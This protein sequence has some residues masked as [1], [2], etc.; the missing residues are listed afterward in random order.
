MAW[1]KGERDGILYGVIDIGSNT[2]R[3]MIYQVEQGVI[4]PV[5]NQKYAAGLAG[6]INDKGEM[7]PAGI[8]KAVE[9]LSELSRTASQVKLEELFAFATA[10]LRNSSNA[11]AVLRA[12]REA[13]GLE[14]RV[15]T[16]TEEA[17]F[18]YYGAIQS[19]PMDSG[20]LVDVGGGSTELVYYR[21]K[22]VFFSTSLPMGSLN[23]FARFVKEI[24]PT[25]KEMEQIQKEVCRQLETVNPPAVPLC[26]GTICGVGGTAR[27]VQRIHN[28]MKKTKGSNTYNTEFLGEFLGKMEAN[29]G[30]LIPRILKVAPERVHTLLPGMMIFRT[31][32]QTFGSEQVVTSPYG[33][34]EGYLYYILE[35]R[36]EL[37]E[38]AAP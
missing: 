7:T 17:V 38:T 16:G 30:K 9:V 25:R 31:I 20:L 4:T 28:A 6:Y 19:T 36:G 10:S 34:R 2:I 35:E 29:P 5:L 12:I 22:E 3:L 14:V 13:C 33:V 1:S 21:D 32:A 23:L 8:D 27:T 26:T 24:L 15:L 11:D 18:D 37:G